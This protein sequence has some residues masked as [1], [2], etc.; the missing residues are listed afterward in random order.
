MVDGKW[1]IRGELVI[2]EK[3]DYVIH[4]LVFGMDDR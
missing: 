1:W 2:D 3:T 4:T